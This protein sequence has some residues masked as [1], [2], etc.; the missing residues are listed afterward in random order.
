MLSVF[1]ISLPDSVNRRDAI[2]QRLGDLMLDFEWIDAVDGRNGLPTAFE[3]MVDRKAAVSEYGLPLEDVEL[4]CALS[5]IRACQLVVDRRLPHALI[6]ED[7]AVP[8]PDLALYIAGKHYTESGVTSLYC[9]TTWVRRKGRKLFGEYSSHS[10]VC[11]ARAPGMVGYVVCQDA[12]RTIVQAAVPVDREADRMRCADDLKRR[13]QWSVV[14]P[15]LVGHSADG[16]SILD[17]F[18]RASR[19]SRKP[20]VLG[21]YIPPVPQAARSLCLGV[22]GRLSGLKRVKMPAA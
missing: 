14:L 19:R 6:L 10:F 22:Y 11:G 18:G 20:R 5:H 8:Q 1:V 16:G 2:S 9:G 12:A 17:D 15:R 7:D 3:E 4:A 21:V 13:G